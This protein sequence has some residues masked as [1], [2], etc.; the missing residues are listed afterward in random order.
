M[1]VFCSYLISCCPFYVF[2][3]LSGRLS[4]IFH[5]APIITGITTVFH[6]IIAI[7][8]IIII[9]IIIIIVII[10]LLFAKQIKCTCW[11]I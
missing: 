11:Y 3:L 9:I 1:A 8:I 7:T 10:I 2:H 4:K 5:C 6:I